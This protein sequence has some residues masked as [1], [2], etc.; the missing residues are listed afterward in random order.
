MKKLLIVLLLFSTQIKAQVQVAQVKCNGV[1]MQPLDTIHIG[2][3][4]HIVSVT[5][6]NWFTGMNNT[7]LFCKGVE[8]R[9]MCTP[10]EYDIISTGNYKL[11]FI[12]S[13]GGT[14]Y[15]FPFSVKH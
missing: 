5:F 13:N 11:K 2:N 9:P 3:T 12:N 4:Q 10:N 1:L 6:S 15:V 14:Y 7:K 8:V